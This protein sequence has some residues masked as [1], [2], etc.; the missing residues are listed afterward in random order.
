MI[1]VLVLT[2]HSCNDEG[3][4]TGTEVA[5]VTAGFYVR[6]GGVERDTILKNVTFYSILRPD[7]LIYDSA[8]NVHVIRFPLTNDVAPAVD[9]VFQVDSLTDLLTVIKSSR[10]VMESYACGFATHHDLLDLVYGNTIID[11]IAISDPA[12]NLSDEE[13]IKIYIKPSSGRNAR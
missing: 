7:S 3:I 9:F 6:S 11:T 5:R 10:L 4:C 1:L 2:F 13:N 12:I 8:Y